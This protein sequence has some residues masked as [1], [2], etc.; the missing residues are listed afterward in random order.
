MQTTTAITTATIAAA[1][2]STKLFAANYALW[3]GAHVHVG[4]LHR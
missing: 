3:S 4:S 2:T 1:T